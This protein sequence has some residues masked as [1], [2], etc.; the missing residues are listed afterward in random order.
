M[1]PASQAPRGDAGAAG[2]GSTLGRVRLARPLKPPSG[3]LDLP[4]D[5]LLLQNS[6]L[7]LSLV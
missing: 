6:E 1:A 5:F 7:V 2:L 4:N 3:D